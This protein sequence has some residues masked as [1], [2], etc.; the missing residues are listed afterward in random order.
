M[1]TVAITILLAFGVAAGAWF[2]FEGRWDRI[3]FGEL[4]EHEFVRNVRADY[5]VKVLSQKSDLIII[6][7]RPNQRFDAGHI[8]GALN[9]PFSDGTLDSTALAGIPRERS[10]LVYCDGG[11]RSRKALPSLRNL[12]FRSIY[13]LHRGFISW[14]AAKGVVE[15]GVA[16]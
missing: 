5:V 10:V 16:T 13:H 7:V 1:L 2:L 9:A 12:G 3:Q 11:Y 14:K 8:P 15:S 4:S 6:D